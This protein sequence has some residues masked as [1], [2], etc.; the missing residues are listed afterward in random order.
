MD[1]FEKSISLSVDRICL[2]DQSLKSGHAESILY[3]SNFLDGKTPVPCE[4]GRLSRYD[5]NR[6]SDEGTISAS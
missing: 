1:L 6:Y 2:Y 5:L 3:G 4:L